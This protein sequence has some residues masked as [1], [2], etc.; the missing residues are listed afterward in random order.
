MLNIKQKVLHF[1]REP[2]YN[3]VDSENVKELL[4]TY[5]EEFLIEKIF[6]R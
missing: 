4:T 3:E 5:S 2:R 6:Q 1:A